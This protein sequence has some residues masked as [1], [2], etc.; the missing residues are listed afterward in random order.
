MMVVVVEIDHESHGDDDGN[1]E[2]C[3]DN[4]VAVGGVLLVVMVEVE[5]MDRCDNNGGDDGDGKNR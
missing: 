3:G 5:M 4:S 2:F 1:G